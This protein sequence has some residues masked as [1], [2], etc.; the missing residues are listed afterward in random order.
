MTPDL[1]LMI[2]EDVSAT[3]DDVDE[4][5]TGVTWVTVVFRLPDILC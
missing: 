4:G 1:P 5:D 3:P 2:N